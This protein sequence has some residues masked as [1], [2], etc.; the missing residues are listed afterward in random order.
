LLHFSR[1]GKKKEPAGD[2]TR[3]RR[4]GKGRNDISAKAHFL[5]GERKEGGPSSSK[6]GR[7]RKRERVL[8]LLEKKKRAF[9]PRPLPK[10]RGKRREERGGVGRRFPPF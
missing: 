2:S 9:C 8:S 7:V 10:G 1:K 3:R 5:R 4:A 6:L